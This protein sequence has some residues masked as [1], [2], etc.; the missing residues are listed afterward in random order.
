MRPAA[1]PARIALPLFDPLRRI[2][3]RRIAARD[4]PRI[5]VPGW[6]ERLPGPVRIEPSP[7]D[8]INATRLGQRLAALA[9]ALD[10]L[11]RQA[12][13][14]A[15]LK[16][17]L[18]AEGVQPGRFRR[19]SPLRGGPPPGCRLARYEPDHRAAGHRR[20]REKIREID[21]ILAH[22]HELAVDA[23]TCPDTS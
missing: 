19:I 9:A 5:C 1:P 14:F 11:P 13:R 22:S 6:T 3:P 2:G 21:E 16:A 4:L 15:R 23:L 12:R 18:D 7:D 10:D 20:K 8:P 17:R